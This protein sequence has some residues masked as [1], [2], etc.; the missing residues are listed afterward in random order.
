MSI[1]AKVS[2]RICALPASRA[3]AEMSRPEIMHGKIGAVAVADV[4]P[5][6]IEIERDGPV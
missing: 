6:D 2:D 4:D 5:V 1:S 3:D